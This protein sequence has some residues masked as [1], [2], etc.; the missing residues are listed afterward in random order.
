MQV[1]SDEDCD[2]MA[3]ALPKHVTTRSSDT[4]VS[5][6]VKPSFSVQFIWKTYGKDIVC[7]NLN[8]LIW[9]RSFFPEYFC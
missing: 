1:S 7:T 3:N 9:I 5:G 2:S 4:Y 6:E 8:K